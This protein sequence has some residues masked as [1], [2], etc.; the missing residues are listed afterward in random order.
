M[1]KYSKGSQQVKTLENKLRA[2][3]T[4]RQLPP[5]PF[6][7]EIIIDDTYNYIIIV[8]KVENQDTVITKLKEISGVTNIQIKSDE[9]KHD[10][11]G[12]MIVGK[13]IVDGLCHIF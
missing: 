2:N 13:D 11:I 10:K 7:E 8:I 4:Q 12:V 9:E 6:I 5:N 1:P 3:D